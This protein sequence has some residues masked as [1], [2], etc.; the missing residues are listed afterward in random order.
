MYY[1]PKSI[2]P[3]MAMLDLVDWISWD[4]ICETASSVTISCLSTLSSKLTD[5]VNASVAL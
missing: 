3:L 1:V 5:C 4:A 2:L